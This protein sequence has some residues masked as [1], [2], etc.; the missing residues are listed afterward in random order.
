MYFPGGTMTLR[1]ARCAFSMFA[2]F[3]LSLACVSLGVGAVQVSVTSI[4]ISLGVNETQSQQ[5]TITNNGASDL[6][7]RVRDKGSSFGLSQAAPNSVL[8]SYPWTLTAYAIEFDGIGVWYT[9]TDG[10]SFTWRH[11][12]T[13]SQRTVSATGVTWPLAY[14]TAWDGAALWTTNGPAVGDT[15]SRIGRFNAT[16]GA[17]ITQ[18]TPNPEGRGL[19]HHAWDGSQVWITYY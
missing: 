14:S 6:F 10:R 17:V 18:L 19:G 7:F 9:S 5:F 3:C 4:S 12:E 13:G 15:T 8:T 11:L 16:T 1:R 2:L